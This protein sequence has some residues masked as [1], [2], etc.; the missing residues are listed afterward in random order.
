MGRPFTSFV[1]SGLW[2]LEFSRGGQLVVR[3]DSRVS[4]S[5]GVTQLGVFLLVLTRESVPS[6]SHVRLPHCVS[7]CRF[8]FSN[9]TDLVRTS[10]LKP[11]WPMPVTGL[12]FSS[13]IL[14]PKVRSSERDHKEVSTRCRV[15][16]V[17]STGWYICPVEHS[18]GDPVEHFL[19]LRTPGV[20]V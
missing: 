16:R 13:S 2:E 9:Y 15:S 7:L 1:W 11:P 12:Y 14:V 19:C 10:D 3:C 20:S 17:M 6:V 4:L 5:T 18:V 8:C